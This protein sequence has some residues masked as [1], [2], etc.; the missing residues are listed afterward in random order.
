MNDYQF[1]RGIGSSVALNLESASSEDAGKLMFRKKDI[2]GE[3]AV[4]IC[5]EKQEPPDA[6]L[7]LG[8]D[9]RMSTVQQ[10]ARVEVRGWDS[11]T[12]QPILG[13]CEA[14]SEAFDGTTGPATAG[15]AHYGSAETGRTL[16]VVDVPVASQEEA[17][18]MAASIFNEQAMDFL[19][20]D[21]MIEGMPSVGAGSVVELKQFGTRFSGRYLV[22]SS[23]HLVQAGAKDPYTTRLHLVRNAAPEP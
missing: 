10:L 23:Q 12:K 11:K 3:A 21:V 19:T 13:F 7:Y 2:S 17:D 6:R 22:K 14:V 16:T 9:F 20:A 5:R 8:A 1:L 15:Q 4:V 18:R